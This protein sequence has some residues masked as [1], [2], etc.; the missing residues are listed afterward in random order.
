M[1]AKEVD[2][3]Q[4]DRMNTMRLLSR[5]ELQAI[6]EANRIKT[7]NEYAQRMYQN[8]YGAALLGKTSYEHTIVK[9]KQRNEYAYNLTPNDMVDAFKR[10]CP[11]CDVRFSEVWVDVR[12]GVREQR[13]QIVIDWS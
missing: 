7:G 5:T 1:F 11:E 12:P 3:T 4:T 6:P 8:I 2:L 10:M 13:E 9:E